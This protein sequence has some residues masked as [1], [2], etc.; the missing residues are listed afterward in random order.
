M[1]GAT[2][3]KTLM[4]I[5]KPI[6]PTKIAILP[7]KMLIKMAIEPKIKIIIR[8]PNNVAHSIPGSLA[9]STPLGL[10]MEILPKHSVNSINSIPTVSTTRLWTRKQTNFM[11]MI[12]QRLL[13]L[14]IIINSLP[15]SLGSLKITTAV[16]PQIIAKMIIK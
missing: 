6:V 16:I 10:L 3:Y 15:S 13:G 11:I 2:K 1:A 8:L 12:F 14:E 4:T 7:D 9:K 5:A